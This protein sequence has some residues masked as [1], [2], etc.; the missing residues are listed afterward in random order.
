MFESNNDH[1]KTVKRELVAE[2]VESNG[3]DTKHVLSFVN[4]QPDMLHH[5]SPD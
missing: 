4:R 1:M 2:D 5:I 3:A